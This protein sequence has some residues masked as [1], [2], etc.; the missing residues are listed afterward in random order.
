METTAS[1][2]VLFDFGNTVMVDS[3]PSIAERCRRVLDLSKNGREIDT[4]EFVA[5]AT[6]IDRHAWDGRDQSAVEYTTHAWLNLLSDEYELEFDQ[7][8]NEVERILYFHLDD[9]KPTDGIRDV[10]G[11]LFAMDVTMGVISNHP[12]GNV[13][14]WEHLSRHGLSRYFRI[15]MSSADYGLKKP[16]PVMFRSC[17]RRLGA[18]PQS[19]WFVG[20]SVK[21]DIDGAR[22]AG[23]R[24]VL[25]DPNATSIGSTGDYEV[26]HDWQ[27]LLPLVDT[28]SI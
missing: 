18:T 21:H 1:R 13:V 19:S 11:K 20:D 8:L 12:F 16:S 2:V 24:P 14:L 22:S 17:L 27:D 5:Y 3:P 23:I 28:V 6:A 4:D 26:I 10:L 7:T 15:V 9:S 25:Y